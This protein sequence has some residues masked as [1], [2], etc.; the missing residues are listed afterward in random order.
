MDGDIAGLANSLRSMAV[1][2]EKEQ[3]IV[4]KNSFSVE[5]IGTR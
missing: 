4:L 5:E 1:T 2:N 3:R